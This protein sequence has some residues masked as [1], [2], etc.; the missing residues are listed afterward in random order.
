MLKRLL[1]ACA[2]GVSLMLSAGASAQDKIKITSSSESLIYAPVYL[3]KAAGYFQQNNLDVTILLSN[4]GPQTIASVVS[5]DI[6]F[7]MGALAAVNARNGGA[8]IVMV[9]ATTTEFGANIVITKKWAEA[10]KITAASSYQDKLKAMK[11]VTIGISAPG[12]GGDQLARYM[13]EQA[14]LNPD[15]DMKVVSLG[16]NSA[17]LPAFS[18]NRVD[19]LSV[20]PPTDHVAASQFGGTILFNLGIG[21]VP[22]LKGSL[23]AAIAARGAW[24]KSH[25]AV[26][27]RFMKAIQTSMDTMR[28]PAKTNQAK[29]AVRKM[30]FA[31]MDEKLFD[32]LWNEQVIGTP[33]TPALSRKMIVDLIGFYN[34]FNKEQVPMSIADEVFTTAYVD[35]AR[36]EMGK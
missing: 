30:T 33:A 21:E 35:Q 8:D 14:G 5:G 19:A 13:A 11:E 31:S 25:E 10:H 3:A 32:Q 28:D 26:T 15:R 24:L 1:A 9:A 22:P 27:V 12:G 2:V 17:F 4:T 36:K 6:E 18:E 34:K 23:G 20:S 29:D 7:V 16:S